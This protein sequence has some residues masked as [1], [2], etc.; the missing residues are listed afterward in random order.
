[1]T[2]DEQPSTR[3]LPRALVAAASV[4]L[5]LVLVA[6][7][8]YVV[9]QPVHGDAAGKGLERAFQTG[10]AAALGLVQLELVGLAVGC[11]TP[12]RDR[13]PGLASRGLALVAWL[14]PAPVL[15]VADQLAGAL[16]WPVWFAGFFL[17]GLS[18]GRS[19][20]SAVALVLS[21][22]AWPAC[23]VLPA[24]LLMGQ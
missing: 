14:G 15:L 22:V 23:L 11:L 17:H 18:L 4:S 20:T 9:S 3:L 2:D 8:V 21:V 10:I 1:M 7:Q 19:R 6:G 13:L 12:T 16:V 5:A 24:V